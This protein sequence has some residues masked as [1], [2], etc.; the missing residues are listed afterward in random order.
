MDMILSDYYLALIY[1]CYIVRNGSCMS[2][3]RIHRRLVQM[4]VYT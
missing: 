2:V 4:S 3:C 1:N